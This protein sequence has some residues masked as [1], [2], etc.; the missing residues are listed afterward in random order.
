LRR[1]LQDL[2]LHLHHLLRRLAIS[3]RRLR[4]RLRRAHCLACTHRLLR[5]LNLPTQWVLNDHVIRL[6]PL[7]SVELAQ[8]LALLA[9]LQEGRRRGV[10]QQRRFLTLWA[11][12]H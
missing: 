5:N 7:A 1:L 4:P 11:V 12:L 10:T 9:H 2:P 6:L 3:T 8:P